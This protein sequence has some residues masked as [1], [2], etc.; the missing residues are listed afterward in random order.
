MTTSR[1]KS[2]DVQREEF[3][4]ISRK[5]SINNSDCVEV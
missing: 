3:N 1:E 2:L 4:K 5:D